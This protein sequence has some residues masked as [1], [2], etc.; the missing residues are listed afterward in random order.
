[1]ELRLRKLF[2][3]IQTNHIFEN[4]QKWGS[5]S[6]PCIYYWSPSP[7]LMTSK[8]VTHPPKPPLLLDV[9]TSFL[10]LFFVFWSRVYECDHLSPC[11]SHYMMMEND[12]P[13]SKLPLL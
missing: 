9:N 3:R 11:K 10:S 8:I 7:Q 13:L 6:H 5:K 4:V 1:M 12:T 2:E